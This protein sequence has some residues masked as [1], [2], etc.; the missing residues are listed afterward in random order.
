MAEVGEKIEKE[1]SRDQHTIS[2]P[3]IIWKQMRVEQITQ[4]SSVERWKE[5]KK[6]GETGTDWN[7]CKKGPSC[8]E[9]ELISATEV[10]LNGEKYA[11]MSTEGTQIGDKMQVE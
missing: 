2:H 10:E 6:Q 8:E 4:D 1:S 11:V 7:S 9:L 3:T 5:G